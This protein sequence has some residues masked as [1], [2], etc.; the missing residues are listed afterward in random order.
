MND[1][2][3]KKVKI[4]VT[5]SRVTMKDLCYMKVKILV[6]FSRVTSI[7]AIFAVDTTVILGTLSSLLSFLALDTFSWR[8]DRF[9]GSVANSLYTG[10]DAVIA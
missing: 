10:I 5:F 4:L 7:P 1:L 3:Y 9:L 6:T 8:R 2:Y